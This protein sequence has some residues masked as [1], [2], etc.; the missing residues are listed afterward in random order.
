M[1]NYQIDVQ[2]RTKL[3]LWVSLAESIQLMFR[4]KLLVLE[5]KLSP[6]YRKIVLKNGKELLRQLLIRIG[7]S[8]CRDQSSSLIASQEKGEGEDNTEESFNRLTT[9]PFTISFTSPTGWAQMFSENSLYWV[10]SLS[11]DGHRPDNS[12][13]RSWWYNWTIL[14]W[15]HISSN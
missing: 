5:I 6:R 10:N 11:F 13:G 2:R 12:D 3:T 15:S 8:T 7:S 9:L 4:E 1:G 14:N